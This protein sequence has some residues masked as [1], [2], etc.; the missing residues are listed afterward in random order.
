MAN[1]GDVA[2]TIM[3]LLGETI[4]T[5]MEGR[6]LEEM[7]NPSL[8]AERSV[9]YGEAAAVG[10]REAESYSPDE[11]DEVEARLRNLGYLE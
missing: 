7:L 11:L 6:V 8:L 1:I 10:I 5:Q 3:Y 4:P 2:P 9:E